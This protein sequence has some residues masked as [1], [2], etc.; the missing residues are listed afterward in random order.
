MAVV[1]RRETRV[2]SFIGA[3]IV[4]SGGN[5]TFDCEIRNMSS[6]GAKLVMQTPT[7][8]PDE[9]TLIIPS[10]NL[11]LPT[12]VCWRGSNTVGVEFPGSVLSATSKLPSLSRIAK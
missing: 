10:K 3:R 9:F 12:R 8:L 5:I 6:L 11:T 2:R 4:L 1:D 7:P